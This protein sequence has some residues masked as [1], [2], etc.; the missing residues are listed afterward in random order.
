M[1]L[2][3]GTHRCQRLGVRQMITVGLFTAVAVI[4]TVACT[5]GDQ[6]DQFTQTPE[7]T[8]TSMVT[9]EPEAIPTVTER[10]TA[11]PTTTAQSTAAPS[12]TAVPTATTTATLQPTPVP[13]A[14]AQSTAAPS[15]TAVPIATTTATLQPT[16]APT[17]TAASTATPVS[18]EEKCEDILTRG[19]SLEEVLTNEELMQCLREELQQNRR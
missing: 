2:K 4:S 11:A 5:S 3:F 19:Y 17:A 7:P 8:P 9:A 6:Q 10:P 16:P 1:L 14:T 13:S 18:S 15:A 12:A